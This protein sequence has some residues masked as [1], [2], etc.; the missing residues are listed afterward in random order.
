MYDNRAVAEHQLNRRSSRS[1]CIYTYHLSRAPARVRK[2]LSDTNYLTGI[3]H[4][5]EE[6]L[7]LEDTEMDNENSASSLTYAR[8]HLVDLAGSERVHKTGSSGGV[9]KEAGHINRSLL[10]L[11]Q[12]VMALGQEKTGHV[13]YRR[14]KLTHLLRDSLSG[15]CNTCVNSTR[16]IKFE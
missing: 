8:L 16:H 6:D 2:N 11:E 7:D 12:V 15:P 9:K 1:H 4:N 3:V 10:Y 5:Q 14:C 13:P